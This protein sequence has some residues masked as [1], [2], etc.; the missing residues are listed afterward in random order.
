MTVYQLRASGK[1]Q[2][3]ESF[4]LDWHVFNASGTAAAA[5]SAFSSA[6]ALAWNGTTPGV[7]DLASLYSTD[8]SVVDLVADKLDPTTG[9]VVDQARSPV[10][11]AGLDATEQLPPNLAVVVSWR[12]AKFGPG[13]RGR[14][15][16]PAV[17]TDQVVA[18]RL[19]VAAQGEMLSAMFG[20][21]ANLTTASY[22]LHIY[23]RA[24]RTSDL[25]VSL[26]IGDV[27]DGQ[28]RRRD[29]LI[30]VRQ[31]SVV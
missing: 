23:H 19:S 22:P 8:L 29:K 17:C 31:S 10:A 15:Y 2:T 1:D 27:F 26:D 30:E 20:F 14:T 21:A 25:I 18:G 6:F 11:L 13:F 9:R 12:T 3:G 7:D 24:T 4:V 5:V 16:M 28:R